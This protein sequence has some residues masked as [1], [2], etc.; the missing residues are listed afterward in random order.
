MED[1]AT[2]LHEKSHVISKLK[3]KIRIVHIFAPEIIQTDASNFRELVQRLTG[4]PSGQHG[5]HRTRN[6]D[7]ENNKKMKIKEE[8]NEITWDDDGSSGHSSST[9]GGGNLFDGFTDFDGFGFFKELSESSH[10]I[11]D[12]LDQLEDFQFSV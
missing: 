3:P 5:I 9:T 2:K 11:V 12:G 6:D 7:Q 1:R 10:D 8:E 4:K